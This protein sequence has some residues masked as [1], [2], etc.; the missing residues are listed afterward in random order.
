MALVEATIKGEAAIAKE[1]PV[2]FDMSRAWDQATT[3]LGKNARTV[4]VEP[5]IA[6]S[7]KWQ[8]VAHDSVCASM[9]RSSGESRTLPPAPVTK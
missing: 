2:K 4:M 9:K 8:S 7:R 6:A 1:L 5:E 3:M